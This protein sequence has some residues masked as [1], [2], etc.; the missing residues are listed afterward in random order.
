MSMTDRIH[1]AVAKRDA[2][3][4]SRVFGAPEQDA[5]ADADPNALPDGT[6][7]DGAG[8]EPPPATPSMDRYIR[9]AAR[10]TRRR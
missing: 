4:R 2:R 7:G 8:A 1:R 10:N 5:Q 3:D 6:P 9:A